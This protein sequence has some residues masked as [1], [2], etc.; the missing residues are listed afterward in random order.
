MEG[1]YGYWTLSTNS[2]EEKLR[3][4]LLAGKNINY[5]TPSRGYE[6][7]TN[8]IKMGVRPVINIKQ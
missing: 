8:R 1:I 2:A 6:N 7:E 4:V 5:D 3:S